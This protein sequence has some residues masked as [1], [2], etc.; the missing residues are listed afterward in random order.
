MTE[1]ETGADRHAPGSAAAAAD[2]GQRTRR[3]VPTP[4]AGK[5]AGLDGEVAD[6][7]F[8]LMS[9]RC[10]RPSVTPGHPS[11]PPG[12]AEAGDPSPDGLLPV[13]PIP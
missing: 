12:G 5:R 11:V 6:L 2:G 9:A 3:G 1:R 8:R 4:R 13:P 7:F 10:G